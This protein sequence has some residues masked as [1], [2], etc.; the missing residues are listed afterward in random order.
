MAISRINGNWIYWRSTE[1]IATQW[2]WCRLLGNQ[3][4]WE[5]VGRRSRVH[6][7]F[8]PTTASATGHPYPGSG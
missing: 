2:S 6:A 5:S 1:V 4:D 3:Q 7:A 8:A